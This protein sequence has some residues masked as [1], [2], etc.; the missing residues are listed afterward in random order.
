MGIPGLKVEIESMYTCVHT[1]T[2]IHKELQ[3][4]YVHVLKEATQDT[5]QNVA[6]RIDNVISLTIKNH[7]KIKVET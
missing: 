2:C 4:D 5:R 3:D 6:R 1:F 7:V